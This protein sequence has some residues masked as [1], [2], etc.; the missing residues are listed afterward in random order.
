MLHYKFE[1]IPTRPTAEALINLQR[2]RHQ[3]RRVLFRMERTKS[4]KLVAL[5]LQPDVILDN[6]DDVELA[7]ELIRKIQWQRFLG[8]LSGYQSLA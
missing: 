6:L 8:E 2:W 1:D 4:N 3:K 7:L 5:L